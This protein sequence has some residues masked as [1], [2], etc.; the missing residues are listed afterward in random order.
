MKKQQLESSLFTGGGFPFPPQFSLIFLKLF[1]LLFCVQDI[2]RWKI[3]H[4]RRIHTS[5]VLF[6]ELFPVKLINNSIQLGNQEHRQ[7]VKS[8]IR[9]PCPPPPKSS[10]VSEGLDED[11]K[12]RPQRIAGQRTSSSTSGFA[13]DGIFQ[14][15]Y[16]AANKL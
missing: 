13:I 10:E 4:I 15:Y 7:Q 16:T 11:K 6:F 8:E 2:R 9:F 14:L 5:T 3:M 1:F 12:Y